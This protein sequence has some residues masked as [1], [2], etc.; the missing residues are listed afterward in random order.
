MASDPELNLVGNWSLDYARTVQ[1]LA[2]HKYKRSPLTPLTPASIWRIAKTDKRRLMS[3]FYWSKH[4]ASVSVSSAWARGEVSRG[5][6][7]SRW[8]HVGGQ[9]C[10]RSAMFVLRMGS[11]VDGAGGLMVGIRPLATQLCMRVAGTVA[12][13]CDMEF[14]CKYHC[15]ETK[16][17][18]PAE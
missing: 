15:I 9:D 3:R 14:L 10:M 2:S 12:I 17:V 1:S 18:A 4:G 16:R 8:G 11:L 7:D 5:R 6:G 13:R